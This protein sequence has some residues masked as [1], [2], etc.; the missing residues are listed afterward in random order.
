MIVSVKV[1]AGTSCHL[2]GNQEI[3][4]VLENMPAQYQNCIMVGFTS[5]FGACEQGPCVLVSD[6]L[7]YQATPEKVIQ[8]IKEELR[9]KK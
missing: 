6:K 5:C 1:C 2:L 4:D 3:I 9:S 8:A 7:I